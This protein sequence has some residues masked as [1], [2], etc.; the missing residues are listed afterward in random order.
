MCACGIDDFIGIFRKITKIN[1]IKCS[2]GYVKVPDLITA[3][4]ICSIIQFFDIA[5]ICADGAFIQV[6]L[7]EFSERIL[8]DMMKMQAEQLPC[9]FR[10]VYTA[11]FWGCFFALTPVIDYMR[12]ESKIIANAFQRICLQYSTIIQCP[13]KCYNPKVVILHNPESFSQFQEANGMHRSSDSPMHHAV[14]VQTFYSILSPSCLF[15]AMYSS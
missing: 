5:D 14:P 15:S 9:V 7:P 11:A 6:L 13:V 12:A 2:A 1:R 4:H 8:P 3:D 10:H